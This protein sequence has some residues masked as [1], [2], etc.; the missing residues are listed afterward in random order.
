M[1]DKEKLVQHLQKSKVKIVETKPDNFT[2]LQDTVVSTAV[3]VIEE[4][5]IQIESGRF[6]KEEE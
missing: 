5:L 1:L 3:K 6:D 4:I 2:L